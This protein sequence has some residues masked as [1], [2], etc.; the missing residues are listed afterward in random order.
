MI[1]SRWSLLPRP[2]RQAPRD[3][4]GAGFM[5]LASPPRRRRQAVWRAGERSA[6][7]GDFHLQRRHLAGREGMAEGGRRGERGGAF[8]A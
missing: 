1:Y 7:E 8:T 3:R 5:L 4:D 6:Q 2:G